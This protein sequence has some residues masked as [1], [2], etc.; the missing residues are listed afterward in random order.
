[1]Q[2]RKDLHIGL[3]GS[4]REFVSPNATLE[5]VFSVTY[6]YTCTCIRSF[7]RYSSNEIHCS[8]AWQV[9]LLTIG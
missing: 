5:A 1:M 3:Q 7:D 6:S 8:G 2:Q 9:D 4:L